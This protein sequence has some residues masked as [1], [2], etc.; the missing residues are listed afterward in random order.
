MN[1]AETKFE[2]VDEFDLRKRGGKWLAAARSWL[3][4]K[5]TTKGIRG[6][7]ITWGDENTRFELSARAVEELAACVTAAALNE[8]EDARAQIDYLRRKCLDAEMSVS[9][10]M[11]RLDALAG[12]AEGH[13]LTGKNCKSCRCPTVAK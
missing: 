8:Y 11:A 12:N 10:L 4:H 6:D 1:E 2:P 3:Q 9:V 7:Q 13:A 5:R